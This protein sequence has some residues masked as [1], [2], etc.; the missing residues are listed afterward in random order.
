MTQLKL[1]NHF[2]NFQPLFPVV[3]KAELLI[4]L[5]VKGGPLSMGRSQEWRSQGLCSPGASPRARMTSSTVG[6]CDHRSFRTTQASSYRC[7]NSS[8]PDIVGQPSASSWQGQLSELQRQA[9][10]VVDLPKDTLLPT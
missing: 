4:E 9:L 5:T 6:H 1:M 2:L 3:F 8:C 7:L 10:S